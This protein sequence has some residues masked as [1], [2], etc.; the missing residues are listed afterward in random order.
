M[1]LR[2]CGDKRL[3]YYGPLALRCTPAKVWTDVTIWKWGYRDDSLDGVKT[4][5]E[6]T[7][8][9]YNCRC[10]VSLGI[11]RKSNFIHQSNLSISA[12]HSPCLYCTTFFSHKPSHLQVA[13]VSKIQMWEDVLDVI[14]ICGFVASV[15]VSKTS[16][17]TDRFSPDTYAVAPSALKN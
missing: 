3:T 11:T 17:V 16:T 5:D 14:L 2:K 7:P 9:A 13:K 10:C 6:C 1:S 12:F 15:S 4:D 8:P